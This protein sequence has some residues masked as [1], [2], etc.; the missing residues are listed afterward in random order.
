[1]YMSGPKKSFCS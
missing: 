1:M